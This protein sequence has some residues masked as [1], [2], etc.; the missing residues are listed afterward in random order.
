MSNEIKKVHL[1]YFSPSGSSEKV[2]K[3][4]ASAID[5]PVEVHDLLTPASRHKEYNFGS[6]DL[7]FFCTMTASLVLTMF[8]E[9]FG[10]L[11]GNGAPF[12]GVVTFSNTQFM[13]VI[14]LE[15]IKAHAE[16]QGFKV[17]ALGA[18]PTAHSLAA[19]LGNEGRPNAD[20]E[21]LMQDFGRR[22]YEKVSSGDYDLHDK[23]GQDTSEADA[24]KIASYRSVEDGHY[25]FPFRE[26]TISD[27][28]IK[29]KTCVRHCPVGAID[30]DNKTFDLDK[31]IGCWGCINRCPKHA[32]SPK[33]PEVPG[34]VKQFSGAVKV[35]FDVEM[36]F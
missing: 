19:S 30:I 33:G 8:K 13:K 14:L 3:K 34:L 31:C 20:D 1:V 16:K 12:V 24:E 36:Y 11:H 17:A 2:L 35:P 5:V 6:G 9:I 29:C 26:K 7:V 28:C 15:E 18:F 27:A 22:V 32:I 23:V 4:I 21:K 25:V 10:C